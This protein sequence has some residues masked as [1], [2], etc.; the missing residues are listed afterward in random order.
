MEF[1]ADKLDWNGNAGQ[2]LDEFARRLP[3]QPRIELTVFGSAPLQLFVDRSFL[4][5]D[6]DL[7]DAETTTDFL[8]QF[9]EANHWGKGDMLMNTRLVWQALWSKDI[10]V[11]ARIIRP[12]LERSEHEYRPADPTLKTRLANLKLPERKPPRSPGT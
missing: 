10:D 1:E 9:V 8:N 12:A 4:S 5:E 7:F 2:R 3:V 6:I 11:R